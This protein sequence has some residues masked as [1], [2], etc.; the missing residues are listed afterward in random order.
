MCCISTPIQIETGGDYLKRLQD[1][2]F[3]LPF[4]Y[5][6]ASV[7]HNSS[8]VLRAQAF[9]HL[10][11]FQ[12]KSIPGHTKQRFVAIGIWLPSSLNTGKWGS[13]TV[14][15]ITHTKELA[16]GVGRLSIRLSYL[17]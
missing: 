2:H 13:C 12:Q 16:I 17:K 11:L 6:L 4:A 7:T 5:V 10:L 8:Q 9:T 14:N 15:T 3:T 1:R